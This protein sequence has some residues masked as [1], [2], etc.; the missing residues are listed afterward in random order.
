MSQHPQQPYPP[1][2]PPMQGPPMGPP[3][4]YGPPPKRKGIVLLVLGVIA[5]IIGGILSIIGAGGVGSAASGINSFTQ[6]TNMFLAP[7]ETTMQLPAGVHMIMS[8][9]NAEYQGRTYSPTDTFPN[10]DTV[11]KVTGPGGQDVPVTAASMQSSAQS[12]N[13]SAEAVREFDVPVA[14]SY[15]ISITNPSGMQE[16]P[17]LILSM[18]QM[19]S[20]AVGVATGFFGLACGVPLAII[21]IILIVIWLIVRK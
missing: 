16:R 12:G 18:E 14:G 5:L 6:G 11:F 20:L 15:T 1:Q 3:P 9:D 21:G 19:V 8:L 7:G 17:V 2:G 13:T 10:N 4:V